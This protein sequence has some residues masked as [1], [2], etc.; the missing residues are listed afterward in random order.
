MCAFK[1]LLEPNRTSRVYKYTALAAANTYVPIGT[2]LQSFRE[3]AGGVVAEAKL[4]QITTNPARCR[5]PMFRR[6]CSALVIQISL[7]SD[8]RIFDD[9][10]IA[11]LISRIGNRLIF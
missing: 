4:L 7:K 2:D 10:H 1:P 6:I 8:E 3:I 9:R 11:Q 5:C